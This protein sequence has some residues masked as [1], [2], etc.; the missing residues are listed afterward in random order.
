MRAC[1]CILFGALF[2]RESV[3]ATPEWAAPRPARKMRRP[4]TDW[5]DV[6][7]GNVE[8]LARAEQHG[9]V[10]FVLYGDSITAFHYGYTLTS[11]NPGTPE[12]WT[13]R[14]GALN[15][16]PMAIAGDGIANVV[17][18]LMEGHEMPRRP[19]RVIGFLIGINDLLRGENVTAIEVRMRFLIEHVHAV[20]PSSHIVLC[21][22]TPV[23]E[24]P[25]GLRRSS[26]NRM[27]ERLVTEYSAG[28]IPIHYVDMLRRVTSPTG[29][30]LVPTLLYDRVHLT[31][32]GHDL[33]LRAL[34]HFLNEL[35]RPYM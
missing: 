3:A 22:L 9:P 16:V 32:A 34:R 13:K 24:Y 2:I 28:G 1:L 14:L 35:I 7:R 4:W 25:L 20:H 23:G 8:R 27:Y 15:A 6:N 30:P 33:A 5:M 31:R 29:L 10:Q 17:W 21:A 18:R 11:R 12:V 26:V 19:P